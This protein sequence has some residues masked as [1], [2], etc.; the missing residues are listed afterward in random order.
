VYTATG[1]GPP[2]DE[3][4]GDVF[5]QGLLEKAGLARQVREGKLPGAAKA[6]ED[7]TQRRR[8]RLDLND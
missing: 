8:Y 7:E 6:E 4:M 5:S 3:G 1:V 2:P